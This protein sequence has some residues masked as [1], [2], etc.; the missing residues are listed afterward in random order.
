MYCPN[1]S[2]AMTLA[3][4]EVVGLFL[5]GEGYFSDELAVLIHDLHLHLTPV[6]SGARGSGWSG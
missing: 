1:L 3:G 4:K 2:S 6:T 5:A